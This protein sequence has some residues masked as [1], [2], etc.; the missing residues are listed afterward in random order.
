MLLGQ[1]TYC[2]DSSQVGHSFRVLKE[3]ILSWWNVVHCLV[4]LTEQLPPCLIER[5]QITCVVIEDDCTALQQLEM[6]GIH[7]QWSVR[8]RCHV[9][10]SVSD[11]GVGIPGLLC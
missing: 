4:F 8:I 2:P 3:E 1:F 7:G 10:E 6:L 11:L 9:L 5:F